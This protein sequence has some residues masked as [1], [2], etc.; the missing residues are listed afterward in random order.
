MLKFHA[1]EVIIEFTCIDTYKVIGFNEKKRIY[2]KILAYSGFN[3][4]QPNHN[5]PCAVFKACNYGMLLCT[6]THLATFNREMSRVALSNVF[7]L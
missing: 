5:Q 2:L 1:A 7:Q 4:I 3:S 6:A